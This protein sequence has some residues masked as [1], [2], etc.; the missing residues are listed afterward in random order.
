MSPVSL[1]GDLR[2]HGECTKQCHPADVEQLE[3]KRPFNPDMDAL[4]ILSPESYV[5]DCLMADFEV[6]RYRKALLVWTSC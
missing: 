3:H 6:R 5:V 4:Y 2:L 1:S